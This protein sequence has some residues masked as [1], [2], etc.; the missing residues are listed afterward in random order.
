MHM[1]K[2]WWKDKIVYQIYPK[3]FADSN[4]DGIGDLR[5]IIEKLPY[6]QAL[7]VDILWL[8]PVFCS[9]MA[10]N[11]YDISDYEHIDPMFGTD[12]DMTEL[13]AEAKRHGIRILLDLV[14][15]HTSDRHAWF[16][17]ALKDPESPEGSF[18]ILKKGVNGGPPNNWRAIFGGSV[19]EKVGDTDLYYYHTFAREQPDL[20]WENPALREKLYAMIRAWLEKGIAGFRIDAIAFIKKDP[21]YASYPPDD[22]DG[23]VAVQRGGE[24]QPGIDTF[25]K[26]L[27]EQTFSRYDCLTVAE[28]TGISL[29]EVAAFAGPDGYFSMTFNFLLC[30]I[31]LTEDYRWYEPRKWD[32]KDFRKC[33]FDVMEATSSVGYSPNFLENHDL[34]RSLNHYIP[35]EDIGFMSASMLATLLLTAHGVPFIYQG[36][37]LGMTNARRSSIDEFEDLSTRDQHERALAAGVPPEQALMYMNR[38]SRDH[39]R[40]PFQWNAGQGAGFTAGEPWLKLNPNYVSVNAEVQERDPDSI[41]SYYRN[42]IRLRKGLLYNVLCDGD[43]REYRAG[44][45]DIIAYTRTIGSESV[46]IAHNFSSSDAILPLGGAYEVLLTNG[47]APDFAAGGAVLKPYQSVILRP[48]NGLIAEGG[49]R[50]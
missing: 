11:G 10:D 1:K 7:G 31:D 26:E 44:D 38:R 3:S 13:I 28:A 33:F 17:A 35:E 25:L 20:N 29:D 30:D 48:E 6:L 9:P 24:N 12:E 23:L 42:L 49:A 39:S 2:P 4:G 21:E 8:C 14:I 41:L 34:P 40:T 27:K 43:L 5:G 50:N 15:N 37:E 32:A 18:Y 19:W 46:L 22:A 45:S 16:Q 47:P 36:E